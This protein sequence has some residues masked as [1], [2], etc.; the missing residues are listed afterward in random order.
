MQTKT[1]DYTIFFVVLGLIVFGMIMISSVSVYPSYKVTSLMVNAGKLDAPNN[2]FYL[3]RNISHVITGL[4][5]FAF[6]AKT[7]YQV[8]EKYSKQIFFGGLLLLI[9]AL[10]IGVAYNGAKGW[11]DIPFLPFSLQPVEFMKLATILYFASFLKKKKSKVA[12]V[13]EGFIPYMA[14][15]TVI[16]ILLVLQ[17]DFGS[18]LLITPIAIG[19]FFVAG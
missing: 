4:F 1:I 17:P 6:V 13:W 18:I 19:M 12:D 14:L 10:S 3:L 7:P 8:F 16:V 11:I 2:H 9:A 15:L 5:I